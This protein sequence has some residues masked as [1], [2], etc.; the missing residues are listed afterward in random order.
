MSK[1][2][3][4]NPGQYKIAGREEPGKGILHEQNK[5]RASVEQHEQREEA[6]R[7]RPKDETAEDNGNA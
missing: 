7:H 4:V 3:K 6:K 5:E 2:N 1:H